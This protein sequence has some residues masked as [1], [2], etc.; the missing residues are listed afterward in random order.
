MRS[1][2][3]ITLI[4][5]TTAALASAVNAAP[6][7]NGVLHGSAPSWANAKNYTGAAD[8]NE[9]VGFRVYLGWKNASAAEALARA[10]SDPRSA[11]YGRY[12]TPQ[13]FRKQFAPS[14]DDAAA[15]QNWLR[16]QG[17]SLVH[18]PANNH[19][20]S[21]EGTLGQAQAAFNVTFGVYKVKGQS[22]R[23]PGTDVS[24]PTSLA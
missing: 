6:S 4:A 8:A 12:L 1:S 2:I 3:R 19:Y 24:I 22:V 5:L 18:T 14:Q 10:V 20:V 17:F 9:N 21:A 15:V 13:Q 16:N 7:A 11:Q 23:S